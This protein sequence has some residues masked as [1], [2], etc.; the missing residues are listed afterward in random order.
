MAKKVAWSTTGKDIDEVEVKEGFGTYDGEM[1]SSGTVLQV[2]VVRAEFVKKNSKGNPMIKFMFRA[3]D[4]VGARAEF[5]EHPFWD[6][7][8]DVEQN[9]WKQRQWLDALGGSGKDWDN[10]LIDT[11]NNVTAMGRFKFPGQRVKIVVGHEDSDRGLR[12]VVGRYVPLADPAAEV[13]ATPAEGKKAK[14]GKDGK[15]SGKKAA[16]P[17]DTEPPF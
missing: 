10:T 5:N 6:Q 14:K 8:I 16:D 13:T 17:Y 4:N 9:A 3:K 2:E 1:P 11:E 12:A 15:K 7:L